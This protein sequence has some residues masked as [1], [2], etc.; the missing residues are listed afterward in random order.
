MA[1]LS[2]SRRGAAG[3]ALIVSG[4]LFVLALVIQLAG[5]SLPLVIVLA[6]VALV[7]ALVILAL[8]AVNNR[9]VQ[10]AL[11]A[12]AVGWAIIAI[13][14]LG[15]IAIPA[16]VVTIAAVVAAVGGVVG[17]IVLYTGKEISNRPAIVFIVAMILGALFLL[18]LGIVSLGS[19]A[20]IVLL[21]FGLALIV[22]GVLFR[23]T[24]GG[25]R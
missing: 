23:R 7:I 10:V 16:T 8:G 1:A 25:R 13:A 21:L 14:G 18:G 19:L 22:A 2:N 9:L 3:I 11:F 6:E 24:Q 4:A 15:V 12:A 17:A 20:T 5:Q